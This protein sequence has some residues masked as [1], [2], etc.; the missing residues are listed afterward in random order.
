MSTSIHEINRK[1]DA[2]IAHIIKTVGIEYGAVGEGFGPADAEVMQMSQHYTLKTKSLY[3]VASLNGKVV[4]GCGI[5]QLPGH[6]DTCELKKLF[7][8][9]ETR[10]LG[11][12]KS[13]VIQCL[14]FAKEHAYQQCYL[15]TLKTMDAAISLY[16]NL[17][18]THLDKPMGDGVHSGC[19]VWM[20][21]PL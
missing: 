15:D 5:A 17:G 16:K 19:D 18:F 4:G 7:L 20:I 21:K 2:T 8:L 14:E 12:G 9:P 1:D 6:A 3:L 10:G 11:L 13:L